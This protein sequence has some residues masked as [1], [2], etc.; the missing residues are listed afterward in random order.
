[1]DDIQNACRVRA[2]LRQ[3]ITRSLCGN[4]EAGPEFH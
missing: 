1:M 2:V 3:Y 4:K